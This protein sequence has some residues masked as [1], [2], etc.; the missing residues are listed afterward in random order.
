MSARSPFG[1][2]WCVILAAS[3]SARAAASD[4]LKEAEQMVKSAGP[5]LGNIGRAALLDTASE[6]ARWLENTTWGARHEWYVKSWSRWHSFANGSALITF[7]ADGRCFVLYAEG[8][9][10]VTRDRTQWREAG[11]SVIVAKLWG[12]SDI[13]FPLA[14]KP[15]EASSN[16]WDPNPTDDA[17]FRRDCGGLRVTVRMGCGLKRYNPTIEYTDYRWELTEPGH[18]GDYQSAEP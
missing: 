6:L 17:G 3:A 10:R 13:A 7:K 11:G 8:G 15:K 4:P 18:R 1:V 14:R 12:K 16:T 2:L 5:A 9:G